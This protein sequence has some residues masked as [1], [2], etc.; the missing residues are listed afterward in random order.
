MAAAIFLKILFKIRA[1]GFEAKS[2]RFPTADL[3]CLK[4]R[5]IILPNTFGKLP[6][7]LCTSWAVRNGFL[8]YSKYNFLRSFS[9]NFGG[10]LLFCMYS[11]VPLLIYRFQMFQTIVLG[12]S[13]NQVTSLCSNPFFN[14]SSINSR[15]AKIFQRI[16]KK[17]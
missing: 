12:I 8:L 9:F 10:L 16:I 3:D 2:R 5:Q 4:T 1:T 15:I 17:L 7:L 6:A 13:S 14:F 11:T